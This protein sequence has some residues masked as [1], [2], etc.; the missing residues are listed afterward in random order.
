MN[1]RG[2]TVIELVISL[3]VGLFVFFSAISIPTQL[4]NNYKNYDVVLE[5]NMAIN[6]I[7]NSITKDIYSSNGNVFIKNTSLVIGDSVYQ[8]SDNGVYK[9]SENK[10]T[11]LSSR[12]F[13]YSIEDGFLIIS[14]NDEISLK[15]N[16]PFSSITNGDINNE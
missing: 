11:K 8:F 10:K 13:N 1:K 15:Y 16:I 4:L 9:V 5:K 7:T 3:S 2:F 6:N 14:D 12:K